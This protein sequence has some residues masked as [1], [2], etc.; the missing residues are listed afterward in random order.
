M[1]VLQDMFSDAQF[2][3]EEL[4]VYRQNAKQRLSVNLRK[5]EF[6]AG[7]LIDSYL[8]GLDHPYGRFSNPEDYDKLNCEAIRSFYQ[9][10]YLNG[11][12]AIF[13]A[14]KLPSNLKDILDGFFGNLSWTKPSFQLPEINITP[15]EEKKYIIQNDPAAVQGAIRI[16]SPFPNRHHPDFKRAAVLNTVF[17]GYFGSR[18]MNNIREDKGYTY[19]IYSYL[20]N[21]I[22]HSAW[23]IST[24][25]GKDVCKATV[26]EVYREM[27]ILREKEIPAEELALVRNYLVGTLLGD[28]DGPFHIM[29]RWKNIILNRL[30]ENYFNET[31]E[32]IKTIS[33]RELRELANEYLRPDRF[34][35][36][37][38]Y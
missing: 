35:E 31:V 8:Y 10:Y 2:P 11:S 37:V 32:V 22:Q 33:A 30:D 13:V 16:A 19:G 1:P 7:R 38:V 6:V 29:S 4:E 25:A 28:M 17:G 36:L 18:L 3:E 27:E 20:H 14:G 26:D 9:K 24:E 21:H 12:C 5:C 34:Y 15:A 23:L